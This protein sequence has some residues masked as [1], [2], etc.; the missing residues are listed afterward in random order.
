MAVKDI[1]DQDRK[2]A[3]VEKWVESFRYY[4]LAAFAVA[5]LIGSVISARGA[6]ASRQMLLSMSKVIGTKNPVVAR[7]VCFVGI[8]VC[9]ASGAGTILL[10]V[11]SVIQSST[12]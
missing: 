1:A 11:F 7:I 5:C 4:L 8:V 12:K 3:P 10:I 6:F 2:N 9:T